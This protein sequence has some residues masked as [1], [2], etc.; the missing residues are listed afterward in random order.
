LLAPSKVAGYY[1]DGRY[2]TDRIRMFEKDP[3]LHKN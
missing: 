1:Q 2:E 3:D